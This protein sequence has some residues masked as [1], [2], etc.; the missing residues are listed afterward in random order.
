MMVERFS[1]GESRCS[2]IGD[3]TYYNSRRVHSTSNWFAKKMYRTVTGWMCLLQE[4]SRDEM[5]LDTAVLVSFFFFF[6]SLV[7]DSRDRL[8]W[9]GRA[10][11]SLEHSLV[12]E[13][14]PG[15]L[16]ASEHR[17]KAI[18]ASNLSKRAQTGGRGPGYFTLP[19]Q[20]HSRSRGFM[21]DL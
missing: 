17:L 3:T 16:N 6:F 12:Q 7:G 13:W 1:R 10:T 20:S 21:Q 9:A 15:S 14:P 2:G 8:C 11:A 5:T 19:S 4:W 18:Q